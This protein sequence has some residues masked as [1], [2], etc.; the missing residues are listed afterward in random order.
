MQQLVQ[1]GDLLVVQLP[2]AGLRIRSTAHLINQP[3]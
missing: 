1:A 3:P 2:R